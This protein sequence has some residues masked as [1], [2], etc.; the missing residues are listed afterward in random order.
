[1]KEKNYTSAPNVDYQ[2]FDM[3]AQAYGFAGA[4]TTSLL[5]ARTRLQLRQAYPQFVQ[6]ENPN[7]EI[8]R[9]VEESYDDSLII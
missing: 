7:H 9:S 1:M 2:L 3:K 5:E 8:D 6:L 4:A